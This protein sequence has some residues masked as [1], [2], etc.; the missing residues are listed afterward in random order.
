M[1]EPGS[2]SSVQVLCSDQVLRD[3][4]RWGGGLSALSTKAIL[5]QGAPW[6]SP[7]PLQLCPPLSL[8]R[9]LCL[10]SPSPPSSH[11]YTGSPSAFRPGEAKLAGQSGLKEE[12]RGLSGQC[13]CQPR[14]RLTSLP[15]S[16]LA[17]QRSDVWCCK[18][19]N[20][21]I[22]LIIYGKVSK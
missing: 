16:Q 22:A 20:R 12:A 2:D 17:C 13:H 14:A 15:S 21:Q 9:W 6:S 5:C 3:G 11:L 1:T 10:A 18:S 19:S 7:F 8:T 4:G